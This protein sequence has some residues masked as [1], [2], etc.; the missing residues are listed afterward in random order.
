MAF[1]S[2]NSDLAE[3]KTNNIVETIA[4]LEKKKKIAYVYNPTSSQ[5][6]V[7]WKKKLLISIHIEPSD[8]GWMQSK[9]KT[10]GGS[11]L[12]CQNHTQFG[13]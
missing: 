7:H 8:S 5:H 12:N 9:K 2:E 13:I 3:L 10:F 1:F 6:I 11:K 4:L